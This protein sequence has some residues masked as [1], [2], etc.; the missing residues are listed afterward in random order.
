METEKE[1]IWG[2]PSEEDR[3]RRNLMIS[4]KNKL[5]WLQEFNEFLNKALTDE[6]KKKRFERRNPGIDFGKAEME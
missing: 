4:P 1:D 2:W 3:I 5:I 6:E